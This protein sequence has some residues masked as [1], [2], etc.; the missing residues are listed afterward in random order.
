MK[1]RIRGNSIR[2]RLTQS[3]VAR[4]G[5]GE[6][7][8]EVLA[9]GPKPEQCLTYALE[10]ADKAD[11]IT[12]SYQAGRITLTLPLAAARTWSTTDTVT[13]DAEQL[14]HDGVV[15]RLLIEKDFACLTDRRGVE[16]ADTFPHPLEGAVHC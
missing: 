2:L 7:L 15:L 16:D 12:A 11:N 9:F 4:V 13:L 8:E 6:R 3:E 10:V 5:A 14:I 1:L